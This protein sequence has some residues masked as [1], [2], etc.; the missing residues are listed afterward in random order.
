MQKLS[1]GIA[2][3]LCY[4]GAA[5]KS[6]DDEAMEIFRGIALEIQAMQ[7]SRRE[8]DEERT[9]KRREEMAALAEEFERSVKQIAGHLVE[10]V[11]AVQSNAES[12]AKA[13]QRGTPS[14]TLA[15]HM[16]LV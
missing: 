16:T 2:I 15:V 6:G 12:M 13:A 7:A 8:A 3:K 1:P 10:A 11:T 9:Q 4:R 5:K 14:V